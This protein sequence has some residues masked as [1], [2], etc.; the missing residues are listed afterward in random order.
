M[1]D[2]VIYH[3]RNQM[4]EIVGHWTLHS[5]IST[6]LHDYLSMHKLTS[7]FDPKSLNDEQMTTITKQRTVKVVQIEWK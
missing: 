2:L 1:H 5:S 3:R 4:E 6:I 7:R